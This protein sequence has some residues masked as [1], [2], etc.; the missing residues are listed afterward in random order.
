MLLFSRGRNFHEFGK[1]DK[2][3]KLNTRENSVCPSKAW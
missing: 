3:M 2:I 1:W